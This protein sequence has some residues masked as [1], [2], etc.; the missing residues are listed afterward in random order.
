MLETSMQKSRGSWMSDK[1]ACNLCFARTCGGIIGIAGVCA[2]FFKNQMRAAIIAAATSRPASVHHIQ[3]HS[4]GTSTGGLMAR[5]SLVS[6]AGVGGGTRIAA[7]LEFIGR[8]S[9]QG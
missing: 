6:P 2:R 1:A 4:L 8:T 7:L 5:M 9:N 3:A